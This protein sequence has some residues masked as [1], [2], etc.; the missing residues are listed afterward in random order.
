[1]TFELTEP[2][3]VIG[4]VGVGSRLADNN[5]Q[6]KIGTDFTNF[7]Y[8]DKKNVVDSENAYFKI[9]TDPLQGNKTLNYVT[10]NRFVYDVIRSPLW[11]GSGSISYT[12]TGQFAIG[13]I[14]TTQIVN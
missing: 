5:Y 10:P 1:M 4:L 3:L 8:F 12:T 7:Y 11:D 6:T 2:I 13:K 14:N 9:I